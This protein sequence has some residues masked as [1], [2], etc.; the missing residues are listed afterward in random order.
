MAIEGDRYPV[1]TLL[2]GSLYSTSRGMFTLIGGE[3]KD[4]KF[5]RGWRQEVY[6]VVAGK[7]RHSISLWGAETLEMGMAGA[8]MLCLIDDPRR[9]L[10]LARMGEKPN[11]VRYIIAGVVP[12]LGPC[13]WTSL[14]SLPV[15]EAMLQESDK[16]IEMV[17]R[18]GR[19]FREMKLVMVPG[20]ETYPL[21]NG[22]ALR[23]PILSSVN[24]K[25]LPS[26]LINEVERF[27][28]F[29]LEIGW[30]D[31]YAIRPVQV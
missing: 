3:V 31:M 18:R 30:F 2:D 24:I 19:H 29:L 5:P 9:G 26:N 25:R 17:V 13:F 4:N 20:F 23:R 1:I 8:K 7:E 22:L 11:V 16:F 14:N 12:E 28:E 10:R 21:R 27:Y 6:P 15:M